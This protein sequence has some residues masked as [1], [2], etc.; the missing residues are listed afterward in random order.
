ME[1]SQKLDDEKNYM[2]NDENENKIIEEFNED[3]EVIKEEEK[4]KENEKDNKEQEEI[5]RV[6]SGLDL[7]NDKNYEH[8]KEELDKAINFIDYFVVV[9]LP[10]KTFMEEWLY[11]LDID[12]LNEK[13][14][15][16][17]QPKVTSYFPNYEK[18]TIA[19]EDS[20]VL[21][22]FPN[23]F[24]AIMSNKQPKTKVF[25]FILDNNY[26]NLNFPRK[27]LTCLIC[28]ENIKKYRELYDSYKNYTKGENNIKN[29]KND[30]NKLGE[31]IENNFNIYIPKCLMIISLYS[32]FAEFE[33]I[34]TEIYRYSLI[35]EKNEVNDILKRYETNPIYT[36]NQSENINKNDS[37]V[38]IPE[39]NETQIDI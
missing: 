20:V 38:P 33:K 31:K 34:L 18:H 22:C 16:D 29:D 17:Y 2:I 8:M 28:Y 27:Y 24:K 32:Y 39:K 11:E 6:D 26:Y 21:H 3:D 37:S 12:K 5:K 25:S 9:G 7:T 14:K 30:K 19:F 13:F 36:E 4:E 1:E 35:K 15:G 10:P 23:G